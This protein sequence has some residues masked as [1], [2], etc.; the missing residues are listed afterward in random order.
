MAS[1]D[2]ARHLITTPIVNDYDILWHK[3]LGTGINGDVVYAGARAP[4]WLRAR[5]YVF[6]VTTAGRR[7]TAPRGPSMPSNA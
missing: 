5:P 4:G 1:V 3:K 2:L 6:R 7:C